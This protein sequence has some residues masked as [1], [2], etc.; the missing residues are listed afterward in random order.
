MAKICLVLLINGFLN[1]SDSS[2]VSAANKLPPNQYELINIY[3][4]LYEKEH[5]ESLLSNPNLSM[6]LIEKFLC[7]TSQNRKSIS[8]ELPSISSKLLLN[9]KGELETSNPKEIQIRI[10][11][12]RVGEV[13]TVNEKYFAEILV[14]SKWEE[15]K[16]E[17][18]FA[19]TSDPSKLYEKEEREFQNG[20]KFWNPQLFID[21]V[22]NEPKQ[23]IHF[24]IKKELVQS[25]D[26][27]LIDEN[28]LFKRRRYSN[29]SKQSNYSHSS[30]S[31]LPKFSYWLYEYRKIRGFFFA[32]L[33]L[34]YFPLDT[35]VLLSYFII[36]FLKIYI[37]NQ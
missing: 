27:Y 37:S 32:K 34:N 30:S 24:K 19:K 22:L 6:C 8:K 29:E 23:H 3:F 35:Q 12:L 20:N 11:F 28:R 4:Y 9:A 2:I 25:S 36:I 18:E 17:E 31:L 14:E 21:N 1:S 7:L 33:E 26:S 5:T 15:P 13:D 10:I 16:L